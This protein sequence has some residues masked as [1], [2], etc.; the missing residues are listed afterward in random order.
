MESCFWIGNKKIS[1]SKEYV[2]DQIL[3]SIAGADRNPD[4]GLVLGYDGVDMDEQPRTV[5]STGRAG[6]YFALS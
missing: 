4:P 3:A 5:R 1:R 6:R 2:R